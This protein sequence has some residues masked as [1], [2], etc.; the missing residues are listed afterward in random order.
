MIYKTIISADELRKNIDNKDFII[1]D[2]RCD[3]K[4]QGYGIDSYTEGHIP[5]S[6]F[7]DIDNDLACEKQPGTGR[8]P[9]PNVDMFCEKLSHWG[10]SNNKQVVIYD[11]AGGAF[12]GR[13]WWMMKWLGHDLVAVL[14]GGVNSWVKEG[15]KL[16]TSPTIFEKSYF[17]PNVRNDM[18]AQV[19]DVEEAQFKMNTI[20]LDARS[21]ERY[22]G[23]ND[24]VDPVAGHVPGAI[25]HPL[26]NNLDRTSKFRSKEELI[27]N[28]GKI[29]QELN[30]KEI[31]S[32]C[33]SGI[34]ACHNI[35]ALEISGIKNV[36][37][38]VGS[39]SEWITDPN[40]P[41]VTIKPS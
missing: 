23:L 25:S 7:V 33:G 21:K 17:E 11:D 32:M 40:R 28:F 14:D 4:D 24:P 26:G 19:S 41:I 39:W 38:Y 36:K 12:A 3:I 18:I 31:I 15:N 22:D 20:L 30:T 2:S 37:L 29:S 27:H 13:M 10:M 16:V 8:H 34:T 5:N 1:F 6:I 9:L 35:L